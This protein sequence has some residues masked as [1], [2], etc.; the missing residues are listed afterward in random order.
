MYSLRTF[1]AMIADSGRVNAYAKAISAAV[2]PGDV[3]ADIGCESGLLSLLACRSGARRVFAIEPDES[4][5][6]AREAALANG[7]GDSIE[8]FQRESS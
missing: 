2:R 5:Q 7:L 3:V 4:I 1:A 6:L 8:F